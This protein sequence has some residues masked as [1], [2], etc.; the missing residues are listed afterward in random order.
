M[1][2]SLLVLFYASPQVVMAA[3]LDDTPTNTPIMSNTDMYIGISALEV[4]LSSRRIATE[5]FVGFN[6]TKTLAYEGGII[7]PVS[8]GQKNY[9]P[10]LNASILGRHPINSFV[11]VTGRLGTTVHSNQSKIYLGF[12]GS[13]K[14]TDNLDVRVEARTRG[15]MPSASA[16]A[17][18]VY[19]F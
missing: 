19:S 18:I 2:A 1:I 16:T 7:V 11:S 4:V 13:T 10:A 8:T 9:L 12:G 15:A 6:V 5:V 3:T 17:G 14:L